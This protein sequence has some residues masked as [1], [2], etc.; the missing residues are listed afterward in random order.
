MPVSTFG[1]R[2]FDGKTSLSRDRSVKGK[3]SGR[4]LQ[5]DRDGEREGEMLPAGL[6]SCD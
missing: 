6:S 1:S 4:V 3:N 5:T 2:F